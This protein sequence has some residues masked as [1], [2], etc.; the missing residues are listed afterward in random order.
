MVAEP[1]SNHPPISLAT[2]GAK[3]FESIVSKV[4]GNAPIR[5]IQP[6]L[7]TRTDDSAMFV[8]NGTA[9]VKKLLY[10]TDKSQKSSNLS[11]YSCVVGG[12]DHL[13]GLRVRHTHSM[14][15]MGNVAPIYLLV[16]GLNEREFPC[17]GGIYVMSIKRLCFGAAQDVRNDSI[18]YVV[19]MRNEKDSETG[20]T[21]ETIIISHYR[22]TVF[23]PWIES[24]CEHYAGYVPGRPGIP[25][26]EELTCCLWCD[27]GGLQLKNMVSPE[28]QR[29]EI[30][31]I[32][33]I[34]I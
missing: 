25:I 20:D 34:L 8:F 16:S 17:P 9:F 15:A 18:G 21:N 11:A 7:N 3:F 1:D 24:L 19:F 5:P 14:N 10:L 27:G 12:T 32:S 23:I 26:P 2:E 28:P 22:N 30:Q 33:V 6:Y 31:S 29:T 13:N 4:N